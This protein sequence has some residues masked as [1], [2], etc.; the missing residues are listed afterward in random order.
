MTESDDLDRTELHQDSGPAQ[1]TRSKTYRLFRFLVEHTMSVVAG[2]ALLVFLVSAV[3]GYELPRSVRVIGLAFGLALIGVGKPTANKARDLLWDPNLI[4]IVD[5]DTKDDSNGGIYN[6]PSQRFREWTVED[7][8]LDWVTPTLAFGKHV[9]LAAQSVDGCWRGTL[10]D[11]E[12][13]RSLQAVQEC[14]NQLE[15]DAK[16]GFVIESQAFT[17]IRNATRKAVMSIVSTFESGTLPDDGEGLGAE[18]DSA[19]EQFDLERKIDIDE[20]DQAPDADVPGATLDFEGDLSDLADA[21]QTGGASAD[22]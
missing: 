20:D 10:S 19:L 3:L 7:G 4:W 11:R 21:T 2:V 13:M 17:I 22:D 5:L 12:L 9:D 18:I 6:V 1:P 14:R 8:S 15:A 16:R